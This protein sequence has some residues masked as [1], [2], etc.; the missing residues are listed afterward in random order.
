[1][2][3][4]DNPIDVSSFLTD[5]INTSDEITIN[6][7]APLYEYTTAASDEYRW[8]TAIQ[9]VD[10]KSGSFWYDYGHRYNEK[11]I[12]KIVPEKDPRG[13]RCCDVMLYTRR[14]MGDVVLSAWQEY[15]KNF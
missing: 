12:M 10:P 3:S 7:D 6:W 2:D 5:V 11:V 8:V 15:N 13:R 4:R 14:T 1:M 9:K